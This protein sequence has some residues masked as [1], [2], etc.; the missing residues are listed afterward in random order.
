MIMILLFR[1][2]RQQFG[3]K[4]WFQSSKISIVL[5]P[6]TNFNRPV[7]NFN[8]SAP[9]FQF[10]CIVL[11]M[12]KRFVS[13]KLNRNSTNRLRSDSEP[14]FQHWPYP[15]VAFLFPTNPRTWIWNSPRVSPYVVPALR[16]VHLRS[17]RPLRLG[18]SESS[19]AYAAPLFLSNTGPLQAP[20]VW[21][22]FFPAVPSQLD[23]QWQVVGLPRACHGQQ[24]SACATGSRVIQV[25]P[26]AAA[27]SSGRRPGRSQGDLLLTARSADSALSCWLPFFSLCSG[28]L[29]ET[30]AFHWQP[31]G[32]LEHPPPRKPECPGGRA[33]T[34]ANRPVCS[35]RFSDEI[36][37]STSCPLVTERSKSCKMMSADSADCRCIGG[38]LI[39]HF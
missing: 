25:L 23:C 26:T 34:N 17:A 30:A 3:E 16:L 35:E 36:G 20:G 24:E 13:W 11:K 18:E 31:E 21:V 19:G 27:D 32:Q 5:T 39:F 1:V 7:P 15:K 8:F 29:S 37:I 38:V 9:N 12:S 2:F 28:I 10:F 33:V 6:V 14:L 4:E 22:C